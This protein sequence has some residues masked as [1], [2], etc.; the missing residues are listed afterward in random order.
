MADELYPDEYE[1]PMASGMYV[2]PGPCLGVGSAPGKACVAPGNSPVSPW[3]D[4]CIAG[5]APA[6]ICAPNGC[7]P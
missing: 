4:F 7:A 1:A 5:Y 6:S 2:T 3:Y